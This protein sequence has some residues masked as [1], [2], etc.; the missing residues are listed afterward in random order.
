MSRERA[1]YHPLRYDSQLE[2]QLQR[3]LQ[4][5]RE[6]DLRRSDSSESCRISPGD[7]QFIRGV[8]IRPGKERRVGDIKSF[9]AELQLH[10]FGKRKHLL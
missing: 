8:T 10:S 5:S 1:D 9:R 7:L 6:V 2:E 3:E 4:G